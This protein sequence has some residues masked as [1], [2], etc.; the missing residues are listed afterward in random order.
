MYDYE[1][2][3]EVGECNLDQ[4]GPTQPKKE[5]SVAKVNST[6]C[7]GKRKNECGPAQPATDTISR[8][9]VV[10]CKNRTHLI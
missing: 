5:Q 6:G 1:G 4:S 10:D 8:M 7:G 2:M 9:A 3:Q